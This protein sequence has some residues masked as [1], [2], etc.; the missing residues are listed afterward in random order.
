VAE[1]GF[2]K[3]GIKVL[4]K[5]VAIGGGEE[6]AG[7]RGFLKGDLTKGARE[8]FTEEEEAK[9]AAAVDETIEDEIKKY[10]GVKFEAWVV[11]AKK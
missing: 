8:G 2:S 5:T 10:G 4:Q 7:L 3:D 6:L 1:A 11:L 9:W